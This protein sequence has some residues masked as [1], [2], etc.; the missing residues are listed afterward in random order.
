MDRAGAPRVA[1]HLGYNAKGAPWKSPA[2][3]NLH[4]PH[5][6]PLY[7]FKAPNGVRVPDTHL[8]RA[9]RDAAAGGGH[10]GQGAMSKLIEKFFNDPNATQ[11]TG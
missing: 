2:R 6:V 5:P 7:T 11:G 8:L 10:P 9:M 4:P 1:A 3:P